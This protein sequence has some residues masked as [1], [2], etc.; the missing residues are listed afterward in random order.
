MVSVTARE[1][2]E[3]GPPSSLIAGD[4][5]RGSRRAG[6]AA[7]AD[8]GAEV[9]ATEASDRSPAVQKDD[10]RRVPAFAVGKPLLRSA[11]LP[12]FTC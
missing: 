9:T 5:A 11:G 3:M 2:R 7:E 4:P 12:R 6:L 10:G 1:M 8:P